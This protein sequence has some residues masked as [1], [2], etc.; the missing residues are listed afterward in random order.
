MILMGLDLSTNFVGG[1]IINDKEELIHCFH[2]RMDKKKSII[3]KCLI[4]K[5]QLMELTKEY[6]VDYI[7][8]EEHMKAYQQGRTNINSLFKQAG[9]NY[10]ISFICYIIFK[11]PI[12][13]INAVSARKLAWGTSFDGEKDKKLMVLNRTLKKWPEFQ[14]YVEMRKKRDGS[15]TIRENPTFDISD[16]CTVALA[17]LKKLQTKSY[18]KMDEVMI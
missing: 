1:C 5:D 8:I 11:V 2:I 16:A 12:E 13:H 10:V 7:F 3:E 9:I 14:R 4:A 17:G 15:I 6:K 18:E